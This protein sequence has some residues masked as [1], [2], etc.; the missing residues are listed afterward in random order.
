MAKSTEKQTILDLLIPA[1]A[2]ALII[3]L[4][5]SLIIF[6]GTVFY[7]GDYQG[8]LNHTLFFFSIG[9]VLV[10]RISIV[11][12]RERSRYYGMVLGLV[13]WVALGAFVK[14][15]EDSSISRFSG[16]I[17]AFLILLAWWCAYQLT[18][19]CTFVD[20]E[21]PASSQGLLA[22]AKLDPSDEY[23]ERFNPENSADKYR[24]KKEKRKSGKG[25]KKKDKK[26]FIARWYL[27]QKNKEKRPFSPGLTVIYFSLAALP[28]FGL[29]Q[30]LIPSEDSEHRVASFWL[31]LIYIS[32]A[33]GL[34]LTTSFLGMRHYL[35][36]RQ[37]QMPLSMTTHWLM[38]GAIL[39]AAIVGVA[40]ILPRPYPEVSLF[41][42]SKGGSSNRQASKYAQL[43]DSSGKE[44]GAAGEQTQK[45]DGPNQ[46]KN[47]EPSSSG[48]G[49]NKD[50]SGN[51]KSKNGQSSAGKKSNDNQNNGRQNQQ[52]N[53]KDQNKKGAN[54]SDQDQKDNSS[55]TQSGDQ[56]KKKEGDNSN[57]TNRNKSSSNP[58]SGQKGSS[59]SE[60]P[61]KKF[62]SSGI[63]KLFSMIAK[64]LKWVI[65]IGLV[66]IFVLLLLR[67]TLPNLLELFPGLKKLLDW[68]NR[69]FERLF[70]TKA[71]KPQSEPVREIVQTRSFT[72]FRNPFTSGEAERQSLEDLIEYSFAALQAWSAD[73]G[74]AYL[75]E[76][77][78]SEFARRLTKDH[79]LMQND[80]VRL[81]TLVS[82]NAYAAGDLPSSSMQILEKF[83]DRLLDVPM[84][85]PKAP[86]QNSE[87]EVLVTR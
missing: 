52:G 81:G 57:Q 10:A 30:S 12:D 45:G 2:P 79:P 85:R 67:G 26:S 23:Q 28:I 61:L 55:N 56:N 25:K 80:I 1:I 83:W 59:S 66:L 82:R 84:P 37:T 68:I 48:K 74:E 16:V 33:L 50:G 60:D 49:N 76:E 43:K 58:R 13:T 8:R 35:R 29:G 40:A 15:P 73:A 3:G 62:Q 31:A 51:Q 70:G 4:I 41:N 38:R 22:V 63:G 78:P 32:C 42:A 19:D 34:L 27:Y 18:W 53:D 44:E 20:E 46:A 69:L 5:G 64:I 39:L 14:F 6:L 71:E 72:S 54:N 36:K 24:S 86:A 87:S 9:I 65:M 47:G 21:R 75:E 11:V 7:S 77:T 17:N